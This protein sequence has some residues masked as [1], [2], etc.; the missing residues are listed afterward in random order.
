MQVF[1]LIDSYLIIK[2]DRS[3]R[4]LFESNSNSYKPQPYY[5]ITAANKS[6][7]LF[8]LVYVIIFYCE[9]DKLTR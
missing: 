7:G 1:K 3:V 9:P 2:H 6:L 8:P 4:P 5:K